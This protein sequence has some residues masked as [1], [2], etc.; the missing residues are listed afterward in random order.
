MRGTDGDET[1]IFTSRKYEE[2]SPSTHNVDVPNVTRTEY[3][4]INSQ[5]PPPFPLRARWN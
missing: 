2:L 3:Q 4:L 5:S 1:Q